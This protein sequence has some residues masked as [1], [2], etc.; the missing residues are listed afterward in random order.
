[1]GDKS[2][3]LFRRNREN[4]EPILKANCLQQARNLMRFVVKRLKSDKGTPDL[5][6]A[7]GRVI[8]HMPFDE[9]WRDAV[10]RQAA[11]S[12]NGDLPIQLPA[13][14]GFNIACNPDQGR[15]TSVAHNGAPLG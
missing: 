10:K 1:M 2:G 11:I 9:R 7:G 3:R 8:L 4:S 15:E 12:G 6:Q 13:A 14:H 5:P